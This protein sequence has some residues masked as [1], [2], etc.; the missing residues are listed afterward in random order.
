M[1]ISTD[2]KRTNKS[3]DSSLLQHTLFYPCPIWVRLLCIMYDICFLTSVLFVVGFAFVVGSHALSLSALPIWSHSLYYLLWILFYYGYFW[4]K[5]QTPA[6]CIWQLYFYHTNASYQSP[7]QSPNTE[8]NGHR[9]NSLS[10]KQITTRLVL[11]VFSPVAW[12]CCF[13]N[14]NKK[15][16]LDIGCQTQLVRKRKTKEG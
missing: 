1:S 16:L 15:S 6:M 14:I 2:N 8:E 7:S 13:F 4:H 9:A 10:L 3:L 12:L 5:G 11:G